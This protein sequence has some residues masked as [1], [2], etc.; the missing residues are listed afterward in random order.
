[1]GGAD[2]TI[3]LWDLA[4]HRRVGVL[5]APVSG[6]ADEITSLAF[7]PDGTTLASS[8]QD[9]ATIL[10]VASQVGWKSRTGVGSQQS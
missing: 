2:N 5:S 1:L 6:P 4:R 9:T 8:S 7:S 3:V 10:V